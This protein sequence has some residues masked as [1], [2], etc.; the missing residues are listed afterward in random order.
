MALDLNVWGRAFAIAL[1]RLRE[2]RGMTQ[3]AVAEPMGKDRNYVS[4][5]ETGKR[6]PRID[7]MAKVAD[8]LEVS[9]AEFWDSVV[10]ENDRLMRQRRRTGGLKTIGRD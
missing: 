6:I 9:P 8:A 1:R 2:A 4:E 3:R 7:T 10:K 5:L